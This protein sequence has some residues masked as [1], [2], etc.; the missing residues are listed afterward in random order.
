MTLGLYYGLFLVLG[1]I[2]SKED[3]TIVYFCLFLALG[4]IVSFEDFTRKKIRNELIVV[5]LLACVAGLC[6][7]MG[8]SLLGYR[9]LRLWGAGEYYLPWSYYPKILLHLFLSFSAAFTLWRLSV[10]PAGDAKFFTV[11][12]FF[13]ALIDP[14]LPGFPLA[15]FLLLLV[16]IFVP[17]GL[18]LG[19]EAVLQAALQ[20]PALRKVDWPKWLKAQAD[21]VVL[22]LKDAW[23]SRWQ[24]L[25]LAVNIFA[26]FFALQQVWGRFFHLAPRT[27]WMP[28]LVFL[29]MTVSW[30][31]LTILLRNKT[32]GLLAFAGISAWAL[33]GFFY[34]RW[35]VVE[36]LAAA[37]RMT[38]SFGM[39]L[40]VARML[41]YWFIER[42]S[43]RE[44]R[45]DQLKV[46]LMLSDTT[47][48]KL[49]A[50]KDLADKMER[51][52]VDGLSE[53]D[54]AALTAWLKGRNAGDYTVYHTVP[55]A[56]WI[57]LG[58][59]LTLSRRCNVV[60]VMTPQLER[61]QE[62]FRSAASRWLS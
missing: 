61:A 28:L 50:E 6:W 30:R 33:A 49:A 46:G 53:K 54:V 1:L 58:S 52:C 10:W 34:W 23:P 60:T 37:G 14:S 42:E 22:R 62:L 15:L 35:G 55:F 9:H 43:L 57:F 20:L 41:F 59:L 13:I 36:H 12:V 32:V 8:N 39:F 29:G 5:G 51:R 45:A 48:E 4:L 18:I 26:L 25:V 44:L 40:S 19:A 47:W 7:F 24:Y 2:V 11:C 3:W 21:T 38:L 16:N 31:G 17:A 27:W 56:L